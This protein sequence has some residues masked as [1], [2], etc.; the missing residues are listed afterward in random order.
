MPVLLLLSLL[1]SHHARS[2]DPAPEPTPSCT[3]LADE[4]SCLAQASC[5][6]CTAA[7]G[8]LGGQTGCLSASL[9]DWIPPVLAKCTK[10][11]SDDDDDRNAIKV[12]GCV[13]RGLTAAPLRGAA[14]SEHSGLEVR[15]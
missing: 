11:S 3:S 8:V 4:E 5:S 6:W 7:P 12:C 9:A 13:W 2:D 10:A 14:W 1:A 15:G